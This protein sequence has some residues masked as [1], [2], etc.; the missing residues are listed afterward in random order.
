MKISPPSPTIPDADP[1]ETAAAVATTMRRLVAETSQL[2][3]LD[4]APQITKELLDVLRQ[5]AEVSTRLSHLTFEHPTPAPPA[6]SNPDVFRDR[7]VK[8]RAVDGF[9]DTTHRIYL[10]CQSLGTAKN[11][12]IRLLDQS[13]ADITV[14]AADGVSIPASSRPGLPDSAGPFHTGHSHP[15]EP[16]HTPAL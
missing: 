4:Q 16:A 14:A 12:I 5:V 13:S 6:D 10:A 11:A 3:D 1:V 2:T 15:S 7:S 8:P 9:N